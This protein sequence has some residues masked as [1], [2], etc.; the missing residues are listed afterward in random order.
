MVSF[1]IYSINVSRNI[2][3]IIIKKVIPK[4]MASDKTPCILHVYA[5]NVFKHNQ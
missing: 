5:S 2:S 1:Q 4:V 3:I